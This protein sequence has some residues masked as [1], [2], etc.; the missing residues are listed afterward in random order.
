MYFVVYAATVTVMAAL[1]PLSLDL[2]AKPG[3]RQGS[4]RLKRKQPDEALQ[5]PAGR[6][7]VAS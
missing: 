3:C 6:K 1:A 4:E 2:I 7:Q 5:L